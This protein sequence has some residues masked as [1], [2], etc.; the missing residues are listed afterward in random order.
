MAPLRPLPLL[1]SLPR[2]SAS[3]ASS[4]ASSSS[5]RRQLHQ[6]VPLPYSLEQGIPGFLSPNALK[7]VAVDW[8]NGVLE[9]LNQ[10]VKG[11]EAENL[12]VLQTLKQ[13][14]QD[15]AKTLAFN[16]ASEAL[17]NSFFLST[18]SLNP[19][20]PSPSSGLSQRLS[21]T[22]SLGSFPSLVSHFSAH[23]A[24]LHPSSGAYIWLVTDP[25][26]NLGVIGTYAGGTILVNE[27]RQMGYGSYANKDVKVLG[28]EIE[29]A[30]EAATLSASEEGAAATGAAPTQWET[31]SPSATPRS[32][33][34]KPNN[35]L[36]SATPS[37][38]SVFASS[39]SSHNDPRASIG[40]ALHP[41]VCVS[42][43]P[44]CYLGDYG[45]WGREEY[46]RKWWGAVD[47][48][49]VEEAFDAFTARAKK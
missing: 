41:L 30:D 20:A 7:T 49:K 22:P 21:H 32:S 4:F 24:G 23:V 8:Q 28:E 3:V 26:G 12:S 46:V 37:P 34:A 39:L 47:W 25:N 15:P 13:T 10:L 36:S 29:V 31:I 1:R 48:S 42:T 35:L 43:H 14:A 6:R 44:H 17:N 9:H 18:L 5:A 40:R 19:T 45:L 38:R 16:Y 11:T 27:R 33:N 2:P